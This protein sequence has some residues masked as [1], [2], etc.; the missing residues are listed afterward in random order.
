MN[1]YHIFTV[2][3][4]MNE[5]DS[6]ELGGHLSQSGWAACGTPEDAD[7]IVLNSCSVRESAE[8][9]IASKLGSLKNLKRE[10]PD[11]LIALMGCM[12]D[13]NTA[14]LQK[15]FPYVDIFA[16]PQQFEE[17]LERARLTAPVEAG[18]GCL[19]E[20]AEITPKLLQY[21]NVIHG[22]DYMCTYCIVPFRRGRERSR[23]I[24]EIVEQVRRQVAAGTREV[25]LLGQTVNRYGHDLTPP[26]DLADLLAAV[27]KI[28]GLWR[29]RFL[30]SH[31]NDFSDRLIDAIAD[32][33]KVVEHVN[34]P[35]Q[36]GD[37]VVL[38]RMRRNYTSGTYRDVIGRIRDRIPGV[39]LATDVIVGF[40]GETDAE[41]ANTLRLLEDLR[42]DVVHVAAYSTRPGTL[43]ARRLADD[44]PPEVKKAR[45]HA[46]E[47]VQERVAGEINAA[48]EGT[49]QQVLVEERGKFGRW[50]GRTRTNKLV[51]FGDSG[52]RQGQL[53]DVRIVRSTPWS[54]QG[55]ALQPTP[56]P[57]TLNVLTR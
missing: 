1:R 23:E 16:R 2:G 50:K 55:E 4:Q 9:R 15:R 49:V 44:V 19:P 27:N 11:L 25:T 10:R 29:I 37:D 32:L 20:T 41:F 46:V 34:L 28:E 38:E 6:A 3:C 39:S 54:L 40:C 14:G 22:C 31:P 17:I 56:R 18:D 53:V 35:F 43:A 36:H 47:Q 42:F 48:L 13:K 8:V 51:F 45:L 5:A 7:L 26:R 57:L 24:G 12:V 21:V 52:D 33:D 30:T